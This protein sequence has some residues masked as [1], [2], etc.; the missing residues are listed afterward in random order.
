MFKK[1]ILYYFSTYKRTSVLLAPHKVI[2]NELII[3][4]A[5]NLVQW[6]SLI[7]NITLVRGNKFKP[8]EVLHS[9][10]QI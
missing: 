2:V 5:T 7:Q 10:M 4:C 8:K 9:N 6:M 3:Y 1:L